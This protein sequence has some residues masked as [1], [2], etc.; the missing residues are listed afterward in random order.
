M[1]T[2]GIRYTQSRFKT[3]PAEGITPWFMTA[4]FVLLAYKDT[5]VYMQKYYSKA[6]IAAAAAIVP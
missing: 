1:V 6:G 3:V 2:S 4:I 5:L